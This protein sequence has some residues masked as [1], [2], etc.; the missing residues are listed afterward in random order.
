[1][2]HAG[3]DLGDEDVKIKR[4]ALARVKNGAREDVDQCLFFGE[5]GQEMKTV[6]RT[7]RDVLSF[8]VMLWPQKSRRR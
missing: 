4:E 2:A 8:T 6:N 5:H 3:L 1:M 7:R